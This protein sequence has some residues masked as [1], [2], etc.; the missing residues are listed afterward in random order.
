VVSTLQFADCASVTFDSRGRIVTVCVGLQGPS[1][2]T[3]G[4]LMLDP[5]TLDTL[6]HFDLPPRQ[7]G[8]G[9][10]FQDFSSGGYF[11]LD[12]H[13]RAVVPTTTRHIF[14]IAET[15]AQPG[16]IQQADYDLTGAVPQGDKIV[17]ALP[18]WSGR[19]WFASINGVVGDIDPA[20]GSV[21][22]MDTHEPIGNSFAVDEAGGVYIVTN[23]ALYR[24]VPAAD[25]TPKV[26]W[27][28][29]YPNDLKSKPGQTE[30]GSGTT[31][32]VMDGGYVSITDNSDPID[33][34]VYRRDTGS[35]V[36]TVPLF[37]KGASDT[38]QS[39]IAVGGAM[40]AENNYG[41]SGP[42]S[43]EQGHTTT[44]GLER[45]DIDPGGRSCHKVWHS[46][47]IAPTVVPKASLANGLVYT[48]THP[49]GD[50]SDPWYLTALDFRTGRT[51]FK[52]LA[53]SGLGFN[54]NY[55]PVTLGPDGTAYVG[56][57]G[58]LAAL[59]DATPPPKVSQAPPRLKLRVH[60]SHTRSCRR[61]RLSARVTGPDIAQIDTVIF[62]Y[63]PV[64]F[65]V[66][67]PPFRFGGFQVGRTHTGRRIRAEIDLR[68]G[69]HIR[70]RRNIRRCARRAG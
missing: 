55:A 24:F 9:N 67:A 70:L 40:I 45:V 6:A 11:Y 68:N 38:D 32:T 43:T 60:Y 51:V 56:V 36:C 65:T 8:A 59:R 69:R 28:S 54:N 10:P 34:V 5:T 53:G 48:Y 39:L 30:V 49:G 58:G 41:Y 66:D 25:G 15:G 42:S 37:S 44:P 16:F 4:L 63:G 13:D 1:F 62:R 31:P 21:R 20:T 23:S 27:R 17:S 26:A 14:V 35:H 33:I 47:E 46:D 50:S 22:S 7:P 19:I 12:N 52:Q 57:L 3:A 2:G 18:D 64:F 29:T 61:R